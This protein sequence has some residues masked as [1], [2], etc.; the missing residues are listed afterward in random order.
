M[1][2]KKSKNSHVLPL[3][4]QLSF[5][6]VT[7]YQYRVLP[8]RFFPMATIRCLYFYVEIS[9]LFLLYINSIKLKLLFYN[10]FLPYF[11][12][13][14]FSMSQQI[15]LFLIAIQHF[16]IQMYHNI[17]TERYLYCSHFFFYKQCNNEHQCTYL[18]ITVNMHFSG[19]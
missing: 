9:V 7:T 3:T 1:I 18:N 14:R 13:W 17:S 6:K 15:D 10:F 11:V 19:T 12:S 2:Q 8:L 16:I 4:L 5:P